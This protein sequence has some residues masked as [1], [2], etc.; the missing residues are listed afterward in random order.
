MSLQ[1][2]NLDKFVDAAQD[3]TSAEVALQNKAQTQKALVFLE[4]IGNRPSGNTRSLNQKHIKQLAE[5][6]SVIG[7][8]TPLTLDRN[9]RLLA[10]GH[11]KA[12]LDYLSQEEPDIFEQL[13][14]DGIPV[15]IM[16]MD[17]EKDVV[18]ALQIEV[19]ENTQRRNYTQKEICEAARKLEEAGYKAITGRPRQGEKSLNRE[20]MDVFRLS[21]RHVSRLLNAPSETVQKNE[22]HGTLFTYTSTFLKQAEKFKKN[23]DREK[24]EDNSVVKVHDNLTQLIENLNELLQDLSVD[25]ES[26]QD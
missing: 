17:A 16:D 3:S 23:L 12:A 6:I 2:Y 4:N 20:L 18:D 11:R 10:G 15:Y 7:L 25:T 24:S 13:F 8:I 26:D 14:A 19:E 1:K 22:P 5:S 21:R 9:Y